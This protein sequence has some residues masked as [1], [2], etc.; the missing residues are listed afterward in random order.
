MEKSLNCIPVQMTEPMDQNLSRLAPAE[1]V[2]RATFQMGGGS[3]GHRGWMGSQGL[4]F[5]RNEV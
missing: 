4:S 2:H 1:E 5:K 3:L